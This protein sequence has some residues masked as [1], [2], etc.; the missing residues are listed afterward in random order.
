[1]KPTSIKLG[2]RVLGPLAALSLGLAACSNARD[3]TPPRHPA[4]EGVTEAT[5]ETRR[6]AAHDDV[7]CKHAAC[8]EVD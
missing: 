5:F 3:A 2:L 7:A 1:M 6:A 4:F 8:A